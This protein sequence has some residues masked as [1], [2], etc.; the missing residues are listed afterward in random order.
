[1]HVFRIAFFLILIVFQSPKKNLFVG[2]SLTAYD[3]GWQYQLSKIEKFEYVNLA[4]SGKHT[5]WMLATLKQHLKT[6]KNEYKDVFIYGGINDAFTQTI[7]IDDSFKN[8]QEMVDLVIAAKARPIVIVGYNSE[9]VIQNTGLANEKLYKARYI[10]YQTMLLKIKNAKIVP[11]MQA[12]KDDA[13]DGIHLNFQAHR[14]LS[15]W[16]I[17]NVYY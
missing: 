12:T 16:I 15:S 9:N 1:M 6:T 3:K 2:D 17:Y 5:D 8:I 7:N 14:K 11:V 13:I 10:K 4:Q